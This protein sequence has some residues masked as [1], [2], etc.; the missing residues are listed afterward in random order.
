MP[1]E[2]V[3]YISQYG[4]FAIFALVFVQ[5]LGFP[6]PVPNE[7]VLMFAGYLASINTLNFWLVL[8]TVVLADFIGTSILYF[9]FYLFDI[10]LFAHKPKWLPISRE[11][12]EK[13]SKRILKRGRWGIYV[14][15]L[16]PYL[17]SYA[18]IAAG[19]LRIRPHVFLTVVFVSAVTWSGG[20]AIA[21]YLLGPYWEKVASS[22]GGMQ[23]AFIIVAIVISVVFIWSMFGKR[24]GDEPDFKI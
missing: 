6:N 3:S 1:Q 10:W 15:R 21:G 2:L 22:I 8:L 4:Y 13:I 16:I 20:Y 9:A 5:E 17:R 11:K 19:L 14:G 23:T 24:S 7:L 12:V 18:S